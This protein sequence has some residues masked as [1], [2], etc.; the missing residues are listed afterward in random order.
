M[1]VF[2]DSLYHVKD[3]CI[4]FTVIIITSSMVK[5]DG[6][7]SQ[8]YYRVDIDKPVAQDIWLC[9]S[10]T[11][12]VSCQEMYTLRISKASRLLLKI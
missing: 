12:S 5:S 11:A 6:L 10:D 3:F 7:T 4:S 1:H 2:D 8:C 9:A